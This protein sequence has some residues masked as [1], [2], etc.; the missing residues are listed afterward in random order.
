MAFRKRQSAAINSRFERQ[1]ESLDKMAASF[2][3]LDIDYVDCDVDGHIISGADNS[4]EM[5]KE[6]QL[7]S[8][9]VVVPKKERAGREFFTVF[10]ED[11]YLCERPGRLPKDFYIS[12]HSSLTLPGGVTQVG[13]IVLYEDSFLTLPN[14][15]TKVGSIRLGYNSSLILPEGVTKV[16]HI[17]LSD[18]ASLTLPKSLTH[19][20]GLTIDPSASLIFPDGYVL[21][22][23]SSGILDYSAQEMNRLLFKH[24]DGLKHPVPLPKGTV[25]IVFPEDVEK[26]IVPPGIDIGV[27]PDGKKFLK[28]SSHKLMVPEDGLVFFKKSDRRNTYEL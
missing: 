26:G 23:S 6:K 9:K 19:L 7:L 25:Y 13:R 8:E 24:Q 22:N 18:S 20:R 10:P 11:S 16:G 3:S 5:S 4:P 14:G 28:F 12:G 27:S 17:S 21:K 2:E 1:M 15:V